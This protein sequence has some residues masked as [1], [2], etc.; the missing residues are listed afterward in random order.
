MLT[1]KV[2][3]AGCSITLVIYPTFKAVI[4]GTVHPKKLFVIGQMA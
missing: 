2:E 4:V 1:P 3:A